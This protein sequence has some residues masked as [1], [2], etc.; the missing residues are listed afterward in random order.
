MNPISAALQSPTPKPDRDVVSSSANDDTLQ[1]GPGRESAFG[2]VL[3]TL[4]GAGTPPSAD[5]DAGKGKPDDGEDDAPPAEEVAPA[6][7]APA[8]P[9]SSAA[10]MVANFLSAAFP[11]LAAAAAKTQASVQGPPTESAPASATGGLPVSGLGPT[12]APIGGTASGSAPMP[13][14]VPSG[15][16]KSSKAQ[17]I[18]A[19]SVDSAADAK[20]MLLADSD[21][22]TDNIVRGGDLRRADNAK[23]A[24]D[25]VRPEGA[26]RTDATQHMAGPLQTEVAKILRAAAAQVE[27]LGSAVHFKPVVPGAAPAPDGANAIATAAATEGSI[28]ASQI[29][30]PEGP[31]L[32]AAAAALKL[33]P[34]IRVEPD[35]RRATALN[36]EG[37]PEKPMAMTPALGHAIS[38]VERAVLAAVGERAEEAASSAGAH[39]GSG[40]ATSLPAG[41]LPLIATAIKDELDRATAAQSR[42]QPD[43][44]APG[45]PGGPM[46]TL[47]IQLRP[48]ELGVVTVEMRLSNGQ[49]ET[50][51]RAS[52]PETAALLH[53]D[54]AILT[55]LLNQGGYK[56]DVIVGQARPTETGTGSGSGGSQQ[57]ASPSFTDGGARPG[58]EGARQRQE[59][60]RQ[61]TGNRREGERTDEAVR[62]RDSGVYL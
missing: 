10:A 60:Q 43:P 41:S 9:V 55:D 12:A 51:L 54:T 21:A 13:I 28:A 48:D 32:N 57:Q 26:A 42:I 46:R 62:P 7:P 35:P 56:A 23:H 31:A 36:A 61:A 38:G 16:A 58:N 30:K 33:A 29:A 19:A 1:Q 59:E 27:V 52:Q 11:A 39:D 20:D 50:H 6:S 2:S 44:A 24:E 37:E 5:T 18:K 45:I 25:V 3:R 22:R 17:E 49:L 8:V 15:D 14:K 53:K 40:M 4:S 47:K 34:Q